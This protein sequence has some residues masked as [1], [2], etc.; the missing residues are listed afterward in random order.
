MEK[1]NYTLKPG[2]EIVL[3]K[4]NFLIINHH[5]LYVGFDKKGIEW[6]IENNANSGV[7]LIPAPQFFC[8]YP[9]IKII[10]IFKGTPLEKQKLLKKALASV[11][12][13]YDMF[14]YNCEHFTSEILTGRP[15]SKQIEN[16][17]EGLQFAAGV[18]LVLGFFNL[19]FND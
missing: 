14:F 4:S 5:A 17:K 16:L 11:G 6:I 10:N 15:I 3:P 18:T 8:S 1:L 9:F 12:K 7:R 2:D 13:S 19:L